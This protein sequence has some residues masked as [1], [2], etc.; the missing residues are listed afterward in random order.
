MKIEELI[1]GKNDHEEVNIEGTSIPVSAL[2]KLMKDGY[3]YLAPYRENKTF[4]LWGERCTAFFTEEALRE[5]G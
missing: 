3:V 1:S 4:H 2:K 5:M